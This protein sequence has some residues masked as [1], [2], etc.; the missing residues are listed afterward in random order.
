M[1]RGEKDREELFVTI[2]SAENRFSPAAQAF[3]WLTVLLVVLAWTLGVIDEDLPEGAANVGAF[4]H[5]LAGQVV[6]ALLFLRLLWRVITP[7]PAPLATRLG[8][9]GDFAGRLAHAGLYALLLAVPVTGLVTL[10]E[11]GEALPLAGLYDIASPWA[12]N[13]ELRHYV[14]EIHELAAHALM[15]LAGVHTTAALAHH[16]A[17]KDGVLRRMLPRSLK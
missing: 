4:V 7:R 12:R 8:P 9:L 11:G 6:I 1:G 15:V 2:D 13:R 3:H 17:F 16:F 5:V 10:F 14:G